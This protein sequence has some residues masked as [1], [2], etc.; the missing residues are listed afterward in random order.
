MSAL[1]SPSK[2]DAIR[3]TRGRRRTSSGCGCATF[4][5][6]YRQVSAR[7]VRVASPG[8]GIGARGTICSVY[9]N[10]VLPLT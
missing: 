6:F 5:E 8:A 10:V 1:M 3:L 4:E 9:S 2:S 7:D